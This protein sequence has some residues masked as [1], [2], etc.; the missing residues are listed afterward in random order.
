MELRNSSGDALDSPNNRITKIEPCSTVQFLLFDMTFP[1]FIEWC[2]LFTLLCSVS[3]LIDILCTFVYF[4][5]LKLFNPLKLKI[6]FCSAM[7]KNVNFYC[8]MQNY[9]S[10]KK[11]SVNNYQNFFGMDRG[12]CFLTLVFS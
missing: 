5:F 2:N 10:N 4:S 12:T 1:Y 7:W 11:T 3:S 6:F 9:S 8:T